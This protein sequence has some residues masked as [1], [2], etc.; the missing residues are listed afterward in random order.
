MK[1]NQLL[2]RLSQRQRTLLYVTV[3]IVALA[4][5]ERFV[6]APLGGRLSELD[7]E[8]EVKENQ[9]QRNLKTLAARQAVLD[10]YAPYAAYVSTTGSEEETI[11]GLLKEIEELAR[12]SGLALLN[13]RPKP[14]TTIDAGK[15]YPVEVELETEMGPL[16]RFIHGLH[17]SKYPLRV[18]QL[19]LDTKG[20][21][22]SQVKVYLL[23]NK[24]VLQ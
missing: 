14:A 24:N 7:Q 20:G 9:L 17:G 11:G 21:R 2:S 23:I 3:G 13:V 5:V 10:A 8:I 6:G 12:K 18:N 19:R 15:R 16:I 1:L 4:L 22:S